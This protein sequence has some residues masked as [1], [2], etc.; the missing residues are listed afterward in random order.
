MSTI[1][2]E[3]QQSVPRKP[4]AS[5]GLLLAAGKGF[6]PGQLRSKPS[7]LV[8]LCLSLGNPCLFS[9]LIFEKNFSAYFL[10]GNKD[11]NPLVHIE[12]NLVHHNSTVN[13]YYTKQRLQKSSDGGPPLLKS[14][15]GWPGICIQLSLYLAAGAISSTPRVLHALVYL[16][17]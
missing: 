13:C 11:K 14:L 3:F 15:N 6:R 2:L 4:E 10:G 1:S 8:T 12:Q 9:F 5:C 16:L 17:L 7:S